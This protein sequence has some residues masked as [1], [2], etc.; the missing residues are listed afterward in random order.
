MLR[1]AVIQFDIIAGDVAGNRQK[2]ERYLRQAAQ[3]GAELA[4]LP[5]LWNCG[6]QLEHLDD[7]AENL[8][9]PSIQFLRQLAKELHLAIVGGSIAEKKE[10]RFYN[11]SPFINRKGE[12]VEKYRKIHLFSLGLMENEFFTPGDEWV[13]AE[14]PP[15]KIG[16]QV[17]YD[18]RFPELSRNL[19]LRGARLLTVP[20]QWPKARERDW[21]IFLQARAI[22]NQC[23][24]LAANRT[25]FD[26]YMSIP[27]SGASVIVSP[28]GDFLA[29]GQDQEGAFV[30]DLDEELVEKVAR[31]D[32][33]GD[34]RRIVD[35][36]DDNLL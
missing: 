14:Q 30:A 32:V 13:L 36:I 6:Y 11:T 27:Y 4:L 2:A 28:F 5:E 10:G 31:I 9:G 34:R 18:L 19:A 12:L 8:R 7:L 24:I 29:D 15:F 1:A 17:C 33:F 3:E 21:R 25:G 35:E 22:E 20:A 26:D 23:F 16:F